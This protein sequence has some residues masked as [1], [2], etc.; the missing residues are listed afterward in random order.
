MTVNKERR[1]KPGDPMRH[2]ADKQLGSNMWNTDRPRNNDRKRYGH[3]PT[4]DEMEGRELNERE[5]RSR[6]N[7]NQ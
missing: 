6:Y 7:R 4:L 1:K 3:C 5:K 2:V